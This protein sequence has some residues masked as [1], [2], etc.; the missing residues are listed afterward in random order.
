M[1]L[2]RRLDEFRSEHIRVD[3]DSCDQE[4]IPG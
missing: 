1:I 3:V 2:R 4:A